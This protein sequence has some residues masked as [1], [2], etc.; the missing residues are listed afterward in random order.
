[1]G[2]LEAALAAFKKDR[3]I[4]AFVQSGAILDQN[5]LQSHIDTLTPD[6]RTKFMAVLQDLQTELSAYIARVSGEQKAIKAQLDGAV[7]STKACLKYGS[8]QTLAPK[9]AKRPTE[10]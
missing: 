6:A 10:D 7:Q 2:K 1:M 9:G 4:E 5:D 3:D 8:T